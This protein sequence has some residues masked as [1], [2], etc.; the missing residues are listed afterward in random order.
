MTPDVEGA[1]GKAMQSIGTQY[2]RYFNK[3]HH[4][5]GTLWEGR[6][7][8]RTIENERHLLVCHPYIEMNAVRAGL[9][10]DPQDYR[11]SSY[12]VNAL[13]RS[14][15]L[16]TPHPLYLA[17]GIDAKRRQR[18]YRELFQIPVDQDTRDAI[19]PGLSPTSTQV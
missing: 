2:V 11:W 4:R 10:A 13:G 8:A 3:R 16:V 5:T 7:Y 6:Y 9:V 12:A 18:C 17:L 1:I 15:G 19:R 14:D